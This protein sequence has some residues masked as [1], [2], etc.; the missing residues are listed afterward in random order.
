M[1]FLIVNPEKWLK[2]AHLHEF[3]VILNT[4][5]VTQMLFFQIL[6]KQHMPFGDRSDAEGRETN[7]WKEKARNGM[8]LREK[9]YQGMIINAQ[10]E[11]HTALMGNLNEV[12]IDPRI[13]VC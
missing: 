12:L 10:K 8:S 4:L 7:I 11:K 1:I 3:R 6:V 13:K 9:S 5:T 2:R